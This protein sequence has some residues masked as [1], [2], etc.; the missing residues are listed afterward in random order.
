VKRIVLAPDG[1]R[2]A[3]V[4]QQDVMVWDLRKGREILSLAHSEEVE[5]AGFSDDG[6]YL[7]TGGSSLA[8]I[9]ALNGSEI[10]RLNHGKP[11]LQIRFIQD[12]KY[13]ASADANGSRVWAWQPDDLVS[14][15]CERL[16]RKI[17]PSQWPA[18]PEES[19]AKRAEDAC[20]AAHLSTKG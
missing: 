20:G 18:N 17:L 4:T 16:D 13:I 6:K 8:R 15:A 9:F 7:A 3:I 19:F 10:A 5:T 11:V 1:E 14:E 2:I 12:G